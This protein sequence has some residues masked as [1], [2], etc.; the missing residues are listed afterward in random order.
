MER[1][2]VVQVAGEMAEAVR[3]ATGAKAASAGVL[4]TQM[5]LRN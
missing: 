5:E 3:E 4:M 1:V 2:A